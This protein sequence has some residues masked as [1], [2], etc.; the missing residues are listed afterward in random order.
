[1]FFTEEYLHFFEKFAQNNNQQWFEQN[2]NTYEKYVREPF[3]RLVQVMIK[4]IQTYEPQLNLAP[5]EAIFRINKEG[6]FTQ[7]ETE[8]NL[9]MAANISKEGKE[10]NCCP[11]FYFQFGAQNG[12]VAGGIFSLSSDKLARLRSQITWYGEEF[13][14]MKNGE[15]FQAKFGNETIE[16]LPNTIQDI[17]EAEDN[18]QT[19]E[20]YF[21]AELPAEIILHESLPDLLLEFYKTMR[22][23]NEFLR[24]ALQEKC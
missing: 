21:T 3:T 20:F 5:S 18:I 8:Y 6:R 14:K 11:G 23:V 4:K 22:P 15:K 17:I 1:M 24:R 12:L 13:E 2:I 16:Q 10:I 19:D 7:G 9:F